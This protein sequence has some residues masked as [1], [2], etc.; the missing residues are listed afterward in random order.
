MELN[1]ESMHKKLEPSLNNS[2]SF[3]LCSLLLTHF[4]LMKGYVFSKLTSYVNFQVNLTEMV[5]GHSSYLT[6]VQDIL[7]GINIDSFYAQEPDKLHPFH[8]NKPSSTAAGPSS[9]A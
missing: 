5:N 3:L 7:Q 4:P 8:T 1:F 6:N 2:V 9:F